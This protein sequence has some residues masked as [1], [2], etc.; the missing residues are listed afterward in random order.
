LTAASS[1]SRAAAWFR[2][3]FASWSAVGAAKTGGWNPGPACRRNPGPNPPRPP[4]KQRPLPPPQ[5]GKPRPA[6]RYGLLARLPRPAPVPQKPNPPPVL[7]PWPIGPVPS[8]RGISFLLISQ[9]LVFT[10]MMPIPTASPI[11]SAHATTGH[12]A[13]T[14]R[15]AVQ[16]PGKKII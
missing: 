5:G 4:P 10:A 13:S 12:S 6:P 16:T 11:L 3:N 8:N 7:G 9:M 1:C 2:K 15:L 14:S